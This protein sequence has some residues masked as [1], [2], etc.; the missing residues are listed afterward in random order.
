MTA[1]TSPILI[2][3]A[4]INGAALARELVL[5]GLPVRVVDLRDISSGTTA[6]ASR[7][8]HGGLRYLEYGEFDLVRESLAERTRLLKLSPQYVRPLELFIP[9]KNRFGGLWTSARRFLGWEGAHPK[10]PPRGMWLVRMGLW[11]YDTYARDPTL[12]GHRLHRLDEPHVPRVND[13]AYRWLCSYFDGQIVFPERFVL[14]LLED[15]RRLALEQGI[16]FEVYTYHEARRDGRRVE[17]SS[18]HP[19]DTSDAVVTEWE[20]PAI[21]NATGAWVDATLKRLDIPSKRLMGGTKGSHFF[22]GHEGL[23]QALKGRA[24]YAEADDG[25]PYFMLPFGEGT[26]VGT[27]DIPYEGDPADAIASDEELDYLVASTNHVVGD[28]KLTRDDIDLHYCGVRPLPYVDA[29]TPGAIT[30]RHWLERH[31]DCEFPMYSVIGGKLTTCR[32]LAEE[33]AAEILS[34]LGMEPTGN[35]R[36]RPLPGAE[37]YPV[38]PGA[39]EA[40]WDRL[41]AQAGWTRQQ[42]EAVWWLLGTRTSE[43]VDRGVSPEVLDGTSLPRDV[44]RYVIEHEWPATLADLVER[45]LMLLFKPG[46]TERCLRELAG[47]LVDAGRLAAAD[48]DNEVQRTVERLRVYHGKRVVPAEQSV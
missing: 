48:V 39:V 18:R 19:R 27:T 17:I 31:A 4:G 44:A 23:K 47:M 24:I 12:P 28:L 29:A 45:R 13:R 36:E 41:A 46:L 32:S 9:V 30:R 42:V 8:I 26:L 25:R 16:D 11:F 43:I 10:S 1:P 33:G 38:G 2:L 15:A 40:E 37:R 3:G 14:A 35:S 5:N 34:A 20:P 6:Y 21:V 7:L 22:T